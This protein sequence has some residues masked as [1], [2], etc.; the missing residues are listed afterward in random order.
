MVTTVPVD[1][2]RSGRTRPHEYFY[3][4]ITMPHG[5]QLRLFLSDGTGSGPR[6]YEIENRTIQ[7]IVIPATRIADVVGDVWSEFQKPGVYL[8]LGATEEGS[9]RL[10]IGKGEN[11]AKRVQLHPERLNF[12]IV[13]LLLG[14]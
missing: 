3:L 12:E 5:R 8:V 1:L 14:V 7:A 11:V 10:Y 6:F 13:S 9:D 2:T 4:E